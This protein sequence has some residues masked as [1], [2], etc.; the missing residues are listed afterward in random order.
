MQGETLRAALVEM[1]GIT[2]VRCELESG[3]RPEVGWLEAIGR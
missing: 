2:S 1:L 3:V